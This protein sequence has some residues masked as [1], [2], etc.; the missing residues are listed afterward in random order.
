[1]SGRAGTDA[2]GARI[3]EVLRMPNRKMQRDGTE[4]RI[5]GRA[6]ELKGKVRGDAGD[7]LDDREQHL[8]GRVEQVKG[9][10]RKGVGRMQQDLGRDDDI[11]RDMRR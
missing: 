7:L 3:K 2:G 6:E 5:R 9:K 10:V 8:K 1:M 4:N 11:D